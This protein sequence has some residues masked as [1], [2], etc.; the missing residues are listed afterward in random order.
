[1]KDYTKLICHRRPDRSF[2]IRGHQFPVCSRCTGIYLSIFIY[3]IYAYYIP[4]HYTLY[5]VIIAILLIIPCAIDGTTQLFYIRESNNTLRFITGFLAGIGGMILTKY[6]KLLI[7][8]Y[9]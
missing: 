7:L 9:I 1:M 8:L 4:I 2:F 3:V 6:V 5:H